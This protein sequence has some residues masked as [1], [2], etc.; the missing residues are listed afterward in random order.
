MLVVSLSLDVNWN[1]SKGS[2]SE[3]PKDTRNLSKNGGKTK[4]ESSLPTNSAGCFN[5][6]KLGHIKAECHCGKREKAFQ[7]TWDGT[8]SDEEAS[9][10]EEVQA[11]MATTTDLEITQELEH[12]LEVSKTDCSS[13]SEAEYEDLSQD[14]LLSKQG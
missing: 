9:E 10:N 7:A 11:F 12:K 4:R 1:K 14:V 8:D 3:S 5:C 2:E 6:G 13:D